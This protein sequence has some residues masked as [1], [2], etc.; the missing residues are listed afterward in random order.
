MSSW[1]IGPAGQPI[2]VR[3]CVTLTFGPCDVDVVEQPE[4]DD[5][6]PEL[7]ILD[8]PHG[9]DHVVLRN[10]H[11]GGSLARVPVQSTKR[12]QQG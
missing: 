2:E 10:L 3:L 9:L 11:L 7:G 12:A 6:H 8:P 1:I 5:V 4:V